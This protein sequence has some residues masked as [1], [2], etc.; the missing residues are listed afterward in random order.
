MTAATVLDAV[1][2]EEL[3]GRL[4]TAALT[5]IAHPQLSDDR[6]FSVDDAYRIQRALVTRRL[7]RGDRLTGIKLG[8]TSRRKAAQMGV[9]DVIVGTLTS[10][11]MIADGTRID[12]ADFVHPRVEPEVAFRLAPGYDPRR[13]TADL[14]DVIDAVAPA[15]EIID[16]RYRNFRFSLPDVVADNTS[17]SGFVIGRWHP[18][19]SGLDNRGVLLEIDD[20]LVECGSTAEV[21]GDPL[22]AVPE[23]L[24][25]AARYGI[26]LEPGAILLAGAATPATYLTAD[27]TVSATVSGLGR[28]RFNTT[29]S[30]PSEGET[31]G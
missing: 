20:Q 17:A 25:M 3:A 31:R 4:D 1:T 2:V 7:G 14:S 28:V 5:R 30:E 23:A 24:R 8:F 22:R 26:P 11:M 15:L 21:L 27:T 12:L 16:S 29:R 10:G 13:G 9:D 19:P 6:S 18:V